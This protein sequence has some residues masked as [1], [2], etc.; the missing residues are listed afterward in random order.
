MK[1][2]TKVEKEVVRLSNQLPEISVKTQEQAKKLID[3]TKAHRYRGRKTHIVHF[4]VVTTKNNWQVL[5]HYYM[6]AAFRY[7]KL[8]NVEFF[9]CMQHWLKNGE[10]VFMCRNRCMGYTNDSWTYAPMSIKKNYYHTSVLDDPR[11]IG[12]DEVFYKRVKKD[13]SYL[14]KNSG[15]RIDNMYRAVNIS[16]IWETIIKKDIELYD[17]CRKAGFTYNKKKTTAVKIAMRHKYDFKTVEWKDLIDMLIYL[18]KD[19]HNPL[20]VCPKNLTELHDKISNECRRK[21]EKLIAKRHEIE[22]NKRERELLRRMQQEEEAKKSYSK[23]WKKFLGIVI[24]GN[25]ITIKPLQSVEEFKEES[26]TMHHCVFSNAYY[27]GRRHPYSLILSAQKEG[28]RIE[29]IEVDISDFHIVQSRGK[30]NKNTEYH[31]DI[32]SL[33]N[34]NMDIIRNCCKKHG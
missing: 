13:F 30:Y 16:P 9:E 22:K 19:I 8:Y 17:W 33:V 25:G 5:R 18:G 3:F 32:V 26:D 34:N 21:R 15:Y 29:T 28:E 10:Y 12:Y 1:P 4:I 23:R 24:M 20:L 6:Y 14:P 31:D 27:D 11:C 2:R 7:R